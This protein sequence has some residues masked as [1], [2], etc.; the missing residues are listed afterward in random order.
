M[1]NLIILAAFWNERKWIETSL[2]QIDLLN[3][4]E[5]I[6]SEGTFDDRYPIHST[7]GTREIIEQFAAERSHVKI[8]TPIRT[9]VAGAIIGFWKGHKYNSNKL[10]KFRVMW[11]AMKMHSYRVNQALTFNHMIDSSEAWQIG[12]WFMTYDCDQFYSDKTVSNIGTLVNNE[13]DY[14][15]LVATERTF[16]KS[17]SS[18]SDQY[19]QRNFNN[20]PHK[21][22]PNTFIVPTRGVVLE[23][24]LGFKLYNEVVSSH[25]VGFYNHYKLK[26]DQRLSQSYQVGD[27][28]EPD[29][30]K[31]SLKPYSD[32]HPSVIEEFLLQGDY[33]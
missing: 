17:F 28:K 33:S 31:Y 5:V 24:G 1:N 12:G 27:R 8:V 7:D 30:E 11:R 3:P 22:Y 21:I 15:Q 19:E 29:F 4:K 13:N 18:Y 26:L 32:M 14:G 23:Q 16:I 20:M 25:N 10:S 2:K 9:N 6:I